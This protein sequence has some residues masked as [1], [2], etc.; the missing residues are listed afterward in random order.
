MRVKTSRYLEDLWSYPRT[1]DRV[2][3]WNSMGFFSHN[4]DR[5]KLLPELISSSLSNNWGTHKYVTSEVV[6]VDAIALTTFDLK[7]QLP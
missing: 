5:N 1:K 2:G 4:N 7:G 3:G 6:V